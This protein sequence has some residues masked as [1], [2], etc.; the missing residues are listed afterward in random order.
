MKT[1]QLKMDQRA[2][3]KKIYRWQISIHK[4]ILKIILKQQCNTTTHLLEW[5]KSKIQISQMLVRMW[6]NQPE[7]SFIADGN[8]KVQLHWKSVW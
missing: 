6:S 3:S 7:L 1:T 8:S 5:S 2:T 4:K